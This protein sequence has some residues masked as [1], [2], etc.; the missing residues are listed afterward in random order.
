MPNNRTARRAL[1][2]QAPAMARLWAA[3]CLDFSHGRLQP[4]NASAAVEALRKAFQRMIEA[5]CKPM[6]LPISEEAAMGFPVRRAQP[7]PGAVHI[8]AVGVDVLGC[9]T[10]TLE[11][12]V[13]EDRALAHEMGRQRA[14]SRLRECCAVPGY[15]VAASG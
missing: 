14:L 8:L 7:M 6:A 11:S 12:V 15:P 3:T 10:C 13:S 4:I 2:A 9:G 1:K 5:G